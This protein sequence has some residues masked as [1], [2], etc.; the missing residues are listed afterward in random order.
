[1]APESGKGEDDVSIKAHIPPWVRAAVRTYLFP[2]FIFFAGTGVTGATLW[3]PGVNKDEIHQ[4]TVEAVTEALAPINN[5]LG[6]IEKRQTEVEAITVAY[7]ERMAAIEK[8][9]PTRNR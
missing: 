4:V 9:L 6:E 2:V 5:R 3:K 7:R 8:K 1:M